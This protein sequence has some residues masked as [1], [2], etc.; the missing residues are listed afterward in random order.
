[1]RQEGREKKKSVSVSLMTYIVKADKKCALIF[2]KFH[3][4]TGIHRV[5]M[6][7]PHFTPG[8]LLHLTV[9]QGSRETGGR[10][11][12]CWGAAFCPAPRLYT[13]RPCQ[14]RSHTQW[15]M[16]NLDNAHTYNPTKINRR[17]AGLTRAKS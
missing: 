14:S 11:I 12:Y 6:L 1:M 8:F 4:K 10:N 7:A 15:Q 3:S 13:R 16:T 17:H 5:D 9:S 2:R